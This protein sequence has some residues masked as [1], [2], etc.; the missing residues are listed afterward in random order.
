MQINSTSDLRQILIN[1]ISDIRAGKVQSRDAT[2][3][4]SL[5]GKILQSAK[6]DL[7]CAR[8]QQELGTVP[9]ATPIAQQ[10][11]PLQLVGNAAPAR[12]RRPRQSPLLT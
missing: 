10:P 9:P 8:F 5:A 1:T 4:A 6:L 3:I 2:A 11:Q 12:G 7:E